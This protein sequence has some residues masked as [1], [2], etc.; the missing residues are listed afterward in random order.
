MN[1][2]R[3]FRNI[4]PF[5][6]PDLWY[7]RNV[8]RLGDRFQICPPGV[9]IGVVGHGGAA[10]LIV[11][12]FEAGCRILALKRGMGGVR[13]VAHAQRAPGPRVIGR[14]AEHRTRA[15]A[16]RDISE[17]ERIAVVEP[18]NGAGEAR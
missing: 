10:A 18:G 13:S 8:Q 1:Y 4:F 9:V 12:A 2:A 5:P 7:S 17:I 6:F 11:R 3:F 16:E 15:A 14:I